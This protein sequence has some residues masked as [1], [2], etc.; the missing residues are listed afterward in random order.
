MKALFDTGATKSVMSGKMYRNLKLGPLDD[1]NLPSVVGANGSSLGVMGRIRCTIAFEKDEDKFDQTFLVCENLQRGVILGKDFARQNCAGVYWTPHNT[2]VLHTNLKTIAETKELVPSGTA[3]IHVKQTTKLPPRSL[4]VVDVNINTTSEDKI[5]MIPDSLCQSRHPNM[6][7]MGFDADLSKKGKDTVVP[8][9]LINLSHTE[10]VRLRKDTVVGWTQKDDAEG[11][12]FQIETLDTTP[13]NYTNPRTPRTFAQFVEMPENTDNQTIDTDVDLQKVFTSASNFIKSPAEVDTHR[14]VDLEDKVIKEETKEKFHKLCDRYDQIISKGSAD[15]GKT[16]LVEMDI[17]T[18]DSPP[19]ACRPYTLP[20]KHHDWVKKEIEILD[21]AGI[22]DKSI[23][24]WASPVVIVP[25]KSKPGEPPKRRM[26]VDFRRL[27]G[28]LPEV[29]NM[30]GGKGCISLVPLPKIDELYAR[31]QGYK[32]FST[33]DLRS[34]Y[35]HI[36]LSESAKP[37]TAFVI[38]GI[39]KYQFNRV[40]FGLAQAPAYFQTLINK[41]LDNI[42]FAMGYLDD[43]II[44]SRSEEEHLDH[45]EQVF[46]RLEEA[47]LKLSLEKCSFFKKHIQYLGHLLSEEGIQPLPEKLESIAKMP[48]PKNQKEVKQFLGLIGYYRKFVPRF[49]DISRVL[50]KLTRKDEE[51]KWTSE[52]DKCFNMLKDYLQE[53]PILRYPDP[54]ARYVLYTD[55]SKYAYAGVLTQTVDGTDHPIAYVSG[56]FRGSQLNWAALTKEAYAI[57]MSVKKLS[58]YLDSARITVRSDHLPLKKFL[59]KNTMNAKVNNWAVELESQKIDFVFIPGIKNV[60]ADTL[61]RLI[62]VD[63]DVKLPEEKEGEEFGYIPFEK[64]PPAQVEICEEVWIN[65]VTQDK[66]TLKLQDPITQNIEINLPLTNQKMKELQ[67]QDP[68]VSHLRKLW[69]ENKLNKTLFTMENDILK[70]VLMINGLLYKPVVTPSILK[71]CLIMLAHDEQGHNGFKRT[72]GSLQTVYYWK[73]MK[74]QIQLHCRRCRTCARHNVISQEFNKEH[75]AVP[76]QPMEFIAMDLI[77]EFHPASSKGNRYALTAICMLTGFTFCIPLKNKTAEEVV[78]AYLNHICCVFGPSKKI[79]T[80]NGTEFKNKMWEDVYK[81]L[82]TQHRVTPIYS[83]QCNGRIEGFHR[84]LK[85]TVGKQIQKG[86]EWDDLVWKATSAYNFFPTESSGISPFFLMFGREAAAKHMLLAE[87]STKYVGDNEGILN[88]KLMQQLYHVVAYNLAKSRTARDGNMITKR[89]NFKPKHLKRNGLVLVRDH[90][91]KAFEPK[92]IDHHI[93]DFC[94][95]HQ[96]LVK[97]NY[98]NKKKVHVK[99][100]K[101]IEMDV[102]TAEFF[103]KERE[104]CT[105]RDAKHVMPIKLIPDLEWKFIENISVMESDNGV[106]IYCIKE[107]EDEHKDTQVTKVSEPKTGTVRA[108]QTSGDTNTTETEE[109]RYEHRESREIAAKDAVPRENSE[110]VKDMLPR[111]EPRENPEIT[112]EDTVPREITEETISTC[113]SK[114]IHMDPTEDTKTDLSKQ[115]IAEQVEVTHTID[116]TEVGIFEPTLEDTSKESEVSTTTEIDAERAIKK[117]H[118]YPAI[119]NSIV[120]KIFSVFRQAKESLDTIPM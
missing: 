9:V 31:L 4:A 75:F 65:E 119:N 14:K 73:G 55:A 54:E 74:R 57:Y 108:T 1:S 12:V 46:K 114:A 94:G 7:M 71:D 112:T 33:L 30:T 63:S 92:A 13:R 56:L 113:I 99:D 61:S 91:S 93:V 10:N 64:L 20:L 5:R 36:G 15:I 17:D 102:A 110:I 47:G 44:F 68:K 109:P 21:R 97:D 115:I 51:F 24:A 77:G 85:A 117:I 79:L 105:T 32:I 52:C 50:N 26:C 82:R 88:L 34:G 19:I 101:P 89:K 67:E 62:E 35:Y 39:G 2:R 29:E 18:G 6:Y 43:I 60:L 11:E 100:V 22:I 48:R 16:L 66:V 41:V 59:E 80:D 69:S 27:N 87:E 58:F 83:P 25:K 28:R 78:K 96:V 49:A 111:Y 76:T 70:R 98:G 95:K 86:L 23:S 120:N 3:A 53:A 90:T 103:R 8:F 104:Q 81:L 118:K 37:K 45:I 72:Y 116:I 106:T 84:F 42:D 38:S 107:A 40:P